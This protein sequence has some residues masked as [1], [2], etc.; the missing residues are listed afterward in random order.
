MS[1]RETVSTVEGDFT[2][3]ERIVLTANGNLQRIL[4][5][6]FNH[7]VSVDIVRNVMSTDN[8]SI[9]FDRMVYL[10]CQG[11]TLCTAT[12]QIIVQNQEMI[13][14]VTEDGIGI[15]QLFRYLNLLPQFKLLKANRTRDGFMREY[16]LTADGVQCDI[17]EEFPCDLF[18]PIQGTGMDIPSMPTYAN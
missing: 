15:G 2:P 8:Q 16:L 5:S 10:K 6:Y 13:R 12:S 3:L 17:V 9:V 1:P 14:L 11:K 7:N 4:S 18:A